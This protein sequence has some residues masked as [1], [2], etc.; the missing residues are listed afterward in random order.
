[1]VS[2]LQSTCATLP[3][4]VPHNRLTCPRWRPLV[5]VWLQGLVALQR[6]EASCA[7]PADRNHL[8]RVQQQASQQRQQAQQPHTRDLQVKTTERSI[9]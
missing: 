6:Q 1:M 3:K 7:A 5:L 2:T 8:K 4:N 9:R